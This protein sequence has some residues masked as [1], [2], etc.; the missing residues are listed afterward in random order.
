MYDDIRGNV[1]TRLRKLVDGEY[2]ATVLALAGMHRLG[3]RATYTV[4]FAVDEM[5]P[6]VG[7]GALG[8]ETRI[9][10]TVAADL[11]HVVG[12]PA[13]TIAVTAERAFLRTLRGG[14]QA[15]V[16]AHGVVVDGTLHL[17]AAIAEADGSTV[18]RGERRVPA[19]LDAAEAAGA[20][21]AHELLAAGGA[22]ALPQE[23]GARGPLH[24]RLFLLPRTQERSSR[25]APALRSAGADVIEAADSAAARAELGQ[26]IPD[27]ILFPSSGSVE[28]ITE[29][30]AGLRE[31][32]HRP[33]VAA[34][35]PSSSERAG[36]SGF[37][38]DVVAPNAEVAS[39]VQAVT[40]FVLERS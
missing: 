19:A 39:F 17:V 23:N 34:M 12:D 21:L 30:L 13:T 3:K 33:V 29:Y 7:Q 26:R 35:G 24:G 5:V 14:C 10:A 20:E 32:G 6:A 18:Y 25:I 15:P 16:G 11:D 4:P 22:A 37:P 9:D 28:A 38:P 27:A 40:R 36:A 31:N 8:I 1:D 2:D